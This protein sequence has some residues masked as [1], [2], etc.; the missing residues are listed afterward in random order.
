[1]KKITTLFKV[2]YAATGSKGVITEEINAGNAWVFTDVHVVA[3][4]KFDGTACLIKDGELY[5]RYDV[6]PTKE[7]FKA[8]VMGTPWN[9]QDFRETPKGAIPCQEPDLITGHHPHWLKCVLGAPEDRYFFEGLAAHPNAP[10]DGTYELCGEKVGVN[11]EKITGHALLKHGSEKLD[12]L[13]WTFQGFKTFL[14]HADIE[15]IV[16]HHADGRM[17]KLRKSDYNLPRG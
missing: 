1:M 13:E 16:F 2:L 9:A 5:K 6:K 8:H 17:C 7:A 15:G 3:T 10:E 14:E 11:A 4:R 12:I